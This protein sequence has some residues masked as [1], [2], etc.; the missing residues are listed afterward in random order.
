MEKKVIKLTDTQNETLYELIYSAVRDLDLELDESVKKDYIE[1]ELGDEIATF[2]FS[3]YVLW[4]DCDHGDWYTQPWSE[5]G[6]AVEI[7]D[8]EC[9]D[10]DGNA[11]EIIYDK[12]QFDDTF[13]Y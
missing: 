9:E 7:R 4:E 12:K 13:I 3:A 6:V 11:V 10:E 5:K 2:N 8:V 1:I